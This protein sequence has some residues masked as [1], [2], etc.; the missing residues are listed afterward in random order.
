MKVRDAYQLSCGHTEKIKAIYEDTVAVEDPI[1]GRFCVHCNP[2][3]SRR[4]PT[5]YL[6]SLHESKDPTLSK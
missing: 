3:G 1:R 2:R 5:I 4:H 6:I